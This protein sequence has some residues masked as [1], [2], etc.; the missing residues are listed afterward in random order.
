MHWYTNKKERIPTAH[1]FPALLI[2][3]NIITT[4][5]TTPITP[6]HTPALNMP[7]IAWQLLSAMLIKIR[8]GRTVFNFN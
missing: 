4:I 7:A 2:S 8:K 6:N 1:F 3:Q 5:T